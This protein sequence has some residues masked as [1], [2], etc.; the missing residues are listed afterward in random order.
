ME[1]GNGGRIMEL[2][3]WKGGM[4]GNKRVQ[5]LRRTRVEVAKV[6]V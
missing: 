4:L 1:E 5:V 2:K 6:R 3:C